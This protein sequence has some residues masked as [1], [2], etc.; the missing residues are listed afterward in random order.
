MNPRAQAARK[1]IAPSGK[2]GVDCYYS[3]ISIASSSAITREADFD[4][5]L[6]RWSRAVTAYRAYAEAAR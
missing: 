1:A 2:T 3:E 5:P 4:N 6:R